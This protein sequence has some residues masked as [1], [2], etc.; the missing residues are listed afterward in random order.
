MSFDGKVGHNCGIKNQFQG[1]RNSIVGSSRRAGEM[2]FFSD[3]SHSVG[4]TISEEFLF[5]FPGKN[6]PSV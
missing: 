3:E 2:L 5:S 1:N 6:A 4:V